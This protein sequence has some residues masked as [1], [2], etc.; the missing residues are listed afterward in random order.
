MSVY[1]EPSSLYT[2]IMIIP[3]MSAIGISDVPQDDAV[4]LKEIGIRRC[5][6]CVKCLTEHPMAC[7]ITDGFSDI[8]KT[9]LDSDEL[10]ISI[11]PQN[12]RVPADI[13]KAVE[14]LSNILEVFTDSGGNVPM[15]C[16]KVKLRHI[17]VIIHGELS[18][19]GAESEIRDLLKKGPVESVS[20]RRV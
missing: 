10:V 8:I 6:G 15:S 18:D 20:F 7:D 11:H 4:C 19:E 13:R 5:R 17:I 1:R 14:R 3:P 12:G 2:T 16:D 9:A